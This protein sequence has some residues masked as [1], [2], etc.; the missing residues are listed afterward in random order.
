MNRATIIRVCLVLIVPALHAPQLRGAEPAD[1][2]AKTIPVSRFHYPPTRRLELKDTIFGVEVEDP[3]RWLEDGTS[4][5]VLAWMKAQDEFARAELRKLPGR[6]AMAARLKELYGAESV[7][8]PIRRGEREF[9]SHRYAGKEKAVVVVRDLR[10]GRERILL[11]PNGWSADGSVSLM[12]WRASWDG[13]SIAY[14]VSKNNSDSATLHVIDVGSGRVS[15]TDV[16]TGARY[17]NPSWTP[18]GDGFYYTWIPTDNTVAV[19]DRTGHQEVRFHRLGTNP[20]KDPVVRK[21]T[22]DPTTYAWASLSRDGHWLI[23]TIARGTRSMD[24]WFR[25]E[26]NRRK[27]GPWQALAVGRPAIYQVAAWHD[28]FYIQ[29]DDGAP[30]YRLL[31]ADPRRPARAHWREI[32]AERADETLTGFRIVGNR[33]SLGYLKDASS[34]IELRTLEGAPV[35]DIALP[36]VGS[37]SLLLGNE[38]QDEAYFVF[39]SL[40]RTTEIYRTS[41]R[42]GRTRLWYKLKVPVDTA[43]Y[44]FEQ[45][46]YASRDGT[47]VPMFIVRGKN[48]RP[49]GRAPILLYGYGGFNASM[50]PDFD[51]SIFPW[52]E[53]GGVFA[54]PN[55]RGGSEYGEEWHRSGMRRLKQNVFDDFI[56]AAEYLIKQGWTRPGRIA[57]QGN[58]NGGL[59]VGA[60]LTQRPDLFGAAVCGVPLLDMLRYHLSGSGKSWIEEYG[61][62][63]NELDFRVL[64]AYSPYHRVRARTKYPSVLVVSADSDDRV[65]PMHARKFAA[66]LQAASTGGPVLLRIQRN[67]G[68]FGPDSV[69]AAVESTADE[70]AFALAQMGGGN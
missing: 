22:G 26:R 23:Y 67:A 36:E 10:T 15:P 66:R 59:L 64:S 13:K 42:T 54:M 17:A 68:H 35:R 55:I 11:D 47:R 7:G 4:P 58:S 70:Y 29:T 32:V 27:P 65:D 56:A 31:Q 8:V 3:Y 40:T 43:K 37:A 51:L 44:V 33:L 30:G 5:D 48:Q 46:F 19:S 2:V 25:D 12:G 14:K 63:D 28:R 52:L 16:I 53:R 20:A 49:D 60:A 41:V 50:T 9:N 6:D 57:I 21:K 45:S 18:S 24:V 1:E 38:D 39:T 34:R 69:S 62:A 61:S